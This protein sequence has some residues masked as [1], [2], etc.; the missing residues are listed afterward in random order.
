MQ[1]AVKIFSVMTFMIINAFILNK[2]PNDNITYLKK[3]Y[4]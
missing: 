4:I 3:M 1:T 2:S